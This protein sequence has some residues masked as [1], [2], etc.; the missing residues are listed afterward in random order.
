[1]TKI[2]KEEDKETVD[3]A[4]RNMRTQKCLSYDVQ[5]LEVGCKY[6]SKS[7]RSQRKEKK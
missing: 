4:S 3:R 6:G 5:L 7:L 2:S 1:M